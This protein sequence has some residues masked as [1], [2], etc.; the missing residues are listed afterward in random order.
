LR[1]SRADQAR[2]TFPIIADQGARLTRALD[3]KYSG[4]AVIIDREGNALFRGGID[5]DRVTLHADA[6]PYLQNALDDVLSGRPPRRA[7]AKSY[8]CM[9]QIATTSG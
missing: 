7:S 9:L 8:G 2:Y 6:E 5:S 4:Y 1:E 3:A